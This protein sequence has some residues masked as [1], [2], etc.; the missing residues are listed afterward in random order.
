MYIKFKKNL[1]LLFKLLKEKKF[2]QRGKS[3]SGEA[4]EIE[5]EEN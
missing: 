1:K 3:F 2:Q 5:F 4:K